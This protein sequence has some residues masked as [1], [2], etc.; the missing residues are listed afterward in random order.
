MSESCAISIAYAE[1]AVWSLGQSWITV[2]GRAGSSSPTLTR[3]ARIDL[4]LHGFRN[5][6]EQPRIAK[7]PSP[8]EEFR[9]VATVIAF[10]DHEASVAGRTQVNRRMFHALAR[11]LIGL[12]QRKVDAPVPDRHG[13][14]GADRFAVPA[15]EC[16]QLLF[17]YGHL[18]RE[19]QGEP[20]GLE[21]LLD[22]GS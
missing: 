4:D 16:R 11:E 5:A 2:A 17:G 10:P 12:G 7:Q 13:D 18:G 20:E 9:R 19:L 14:L 8:P 15:R 1:A 6:L 22:H 21:H 3:R